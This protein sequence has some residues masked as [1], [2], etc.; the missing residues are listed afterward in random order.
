MIA[1]RFQ[2]ANSSDRLA[3]SY[4]FYG[5]H[6]IPV[7]HSNSLD[8]IPTQP[9]EFSLPT[10]H[11]LQSYVVDDENDVFEDASDTFHADAPSSTDPVLVDWIV[12]FRECDRINQLFFE[13]HV[14]EALQLAVAQ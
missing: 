5:T 12:A 10:T 13:N 7:P 3:N 9:N 11:S 14:N 8:A 2:M 6:P 4:F 1:F